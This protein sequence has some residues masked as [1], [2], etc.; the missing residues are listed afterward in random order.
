MICNGWH[1]GV[2]LLQ[3]YLSRTPESITRIIR[4]HLSILALVLDGEETAACISS[5]EVNDERQWTQGR[6]LVSRHWGSVSASRCTSRSPFSNPSILAVFLGENERTRF[7]FWPSNKLCDMS[8]SYSFRS[9]SSLPSGLLFSCECRQHV[10]TWFDE[11][12]ADLGQIQVSNVIV[13][14]DT[15]GN[16]SID[17]LLSL[18]W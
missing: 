2:V 7:W 12:G 17:Q 10:S 9:R 1:V 16:E 13:D 5:D 15:G 6:M 11:H 8:S 3:S 14:A 4:S 18:L